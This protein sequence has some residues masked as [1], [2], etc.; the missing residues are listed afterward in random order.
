MI[1][2]PQ[3]TPAS[4]YWAT[5]DGRIYSSASAAIVPSTNTDYTAWLAAGHAA[6]V[7][8]KDASGAQ[9]GAAL[10]EVLTSFGLP[11]S[12]PPTAPQLIAYAEAKQVALCDGGITVN[13]GTAS[14]PDE[15]NV[16]SDVKGRSLVTGA[17]QIVGLAS[18]AGQAAPTFNWINDGGVQLMLTSAQMMKIGLT[19]GTFVQA[20]YTA[21][22][23]VLAAISA[24]T[25][26]TTA[27][28]DAATAWPAT[29]Y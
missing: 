7:W 16:A 14:T 8:P 10:D 9:S 26:T 21:L 1:T 2:L 22:G 11:A 28:I 24:G 19:L 13:V 3:F 6:T 23:T 17:V 25:I 29:V 4:W 18:Q 20:T 12:S 27:Q 5:A 15:V